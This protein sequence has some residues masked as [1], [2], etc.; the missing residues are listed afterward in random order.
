MNEEDVESAGVFSFTEEKRCRYM[1]LAFGRNVNAQQELACAAQGGR[2][3]W[4]PM[5][6]K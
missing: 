4:Y 6:R 1:A 3:G 5:A 2:T